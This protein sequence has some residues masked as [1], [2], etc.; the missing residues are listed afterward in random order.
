M[1]V[2]ALILAAGLGRRMGGPSKLT[3][4]L[5]GKPVVAHVVDAVTAAG[6][7]PP[8]V[9]LGDRADEVRAA[10]GERTATFVVAADYAEGMSASLR[11]GLAAAP[12]EWDAVLVLL[13]DM[14]L[15]QPATLSALG[16]ALLSPQA[17][18]IPEYDGQRG[19]PVGWGRDHWPALVALT[20]DTGARSL[21][22]RI[23]V[24]F[25]PVDD[26]GILADVD[27]PEA[28]AALRDR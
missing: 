1:K 5:H 18:V 4:D 28:L 19:N 3:A 25:V 14:P 9:V 15:V 2:G 8:L 6:L 20:G 23:G 21:I 22:P 11:A 27:T 26:P 7:G 10:V 17:V 16:A 12:A 24:T 13:G